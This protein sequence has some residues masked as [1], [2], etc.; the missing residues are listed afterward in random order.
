[1]NDAFINCPCV[2]Q[3]P[4][5]CVCMLIN[6]LRI[7]YRVDPGTSLPGPPGTPHSVSCPCPYFMP[8][9]NKIYG[10]TSCARFFYSNS[11]SNATTIKCKERYRYIPQSAV[12]PYLFPCPLHKSY[13]PSQ[14]LPRYIRALTP[15]RAR[16][17]ARW[18][19]S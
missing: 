3:N 7:I 2:A 13:H 15:P 12:R 16:L 4:N 1:M 11:I 8:P 5:H 6:I 10:G 17:P 18:R 14:K 19:L 9:A